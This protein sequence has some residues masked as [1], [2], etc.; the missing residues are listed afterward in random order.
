MA[1]TWLC[2]Q[3][4]SRPI[5]ALSCR[6]V[7]DWNG[8]SDGKCSDA[9]DKTNKKASNKEMVCKTLSQIHGEGNLLVPKHSTCVKTHKMAIYRPQMAV[10][11]IQ[12]QLKDGS[13]S[14]GVGGWKLCHCDTADGKHSKANIKTIKNVSEHGMMHDTPSKIQAGG[15]LLVPQH[16]MHSKMCNRS[17]HGH[18][19]PM[20]S[21]LLE[22]LSSLLEGLSF[23]SLDGTERCVGDAIYEKCL[24]TNVVRNQRH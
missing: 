22:G 19:L 1:P 23:Q 15:D 3:S 16:P 11:P 14:Q 10:L 6:L 17:I 8:A 5:M 21:S 13:T 20:S 7:A 18:Q 2:V 24:N 4:S 12:Q 9:N